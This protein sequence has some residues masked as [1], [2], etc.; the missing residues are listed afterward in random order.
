MQSSGAQEGQRHPAPSQHILLGLVSWQHWLIGLAGLRRGLAQNGG[1]R[2]LPLII[3]SLRFSESRGHTATKSK[4]CGRRVAQTMGARRDKRRLCLV[5]LASHIAHY[6]VMLPLLTVTSG[7]IV[8][9]ELREILV[10]RLVQ[11]SLQCLEKV[12]R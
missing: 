9:E 8:I 5:G 3:F 11:I 10:G 12:P 7:V 1:I 2:S 6:R 4:P